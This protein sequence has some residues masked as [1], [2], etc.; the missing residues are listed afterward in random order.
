MVAYNDNNLLEKQMES[1]QAILVKERLNNNRYNK[2]SNENLTH[3]VLTTEDRV[4]VKKYET[5]DNFL[6]V[7]HDRIEEDK[8]EDNY[9]SNLDSPGAL[10]K[11]RTSLNILPGSVLD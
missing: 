11:R 1:E 8:D 10:R 5:K 7:Y 3:L 9:T 4:R 2:M 6:P